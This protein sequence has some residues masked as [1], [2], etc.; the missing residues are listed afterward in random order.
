MNE[1]S[2]GDMSQLPDMKTVPLPDDGLILLPVRD[3]V[4]FPGTVFPVSTGRAK[5]IAAI[6]QVIR[7]SRPVGLLLQRNPAVND[8]KEG[9]LHL[10]GC[11]ANILRLMT[12]PDGAHHI[13][14][15]GV[16]RFRLIE[17]LQG[18]PFPVGRVQ[19]LPDVT[20]RSPQVEAQYLHLRNQAAELL[21]MLPQSPSGFEEAAQA[22][23]E[24]GTLA[25]LAAAYSD[26][27]IGEK[28]EI[29]ETIDIAVRLDKVSR[30]LARRLAVLRIT[31]EISERT[32]AAFDERHRQAILRE[33]LAAI[34]QELGE[35]DGN[36]EEVAQLGAAITRAGMPTEAE[37]MAR[38]ELG[39]FARLSE[40][41]GEGAVL[42]N[43]LDWMIE[44]PWQLP[45][46]RPVSLIQARNI[47]NADHYG[48]EKV[49][50]RIVEFMAVHK[51][52]PE[53]RAPILCF[54]GPP[55]VGKTSLG[56]SIARAL[57][58][59]FVR[60]SLGGV[61]DE[62]EIRGHRRTYIGALPGSI[63]Q[64]VRRAGSRN[65]VLMLDEIDKLGHGIQGDP[66][67]ALL[68]VLDPEQNS[69]F[70]DNYLGVD[71]DLSQIVFLTT[72]NMLEGIPRPLLDRMEVIN[73]PGYTEEEK[74]EI[75][76]RYLVLRQLRACGLQNERIRFTPAA[77]RLIVRSY[78]RE[79]GVRQLES[80]IGAVLRAAAVLHAEGKPA[81]CKIG[82]KQVETALGV[83]RF[84]NETALRTSLTGVATGLAWTPAGGDILF[85]EASRAPG[86]GRLILTGQLGEVMR[87]SA[88]TALSLLKAQAGQL[89]LK[90][91][92]FESVDI[93]VHVP[94]GAT[95]KDGPSAG[96]AIYTALASLFLDRTVR[97]D[98][99]MTGEI[100]LRGAVLPVGGIKE[101][102]LAASAAG[103]TRVMLP[104]RNRRE[105][106]D[107][108]ESTRKQL[109]FIWLDAADEALLK[110]LQ[111]EPGG[112]TPQ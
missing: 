92:S 16:E 78:T 76:K 3:L 39:R 95:P 104:S 60:I 66:S 111:P 88:Q 41:A 47:L 109:E 32:R 102:M 89:G 23:T 55:G 79:A 29:L 34:Q 61:H 74:L 52:S 91:K 69:A 46:S 44:L 68:E 63:L 100:S 54:A 12:S 40:A 70:R 38:K 50:A 49:K 4:P 2:G 87:E 31:R 84:E 62:A 97:S 48:L 83:P 18:P 56:Q 26:I 30:I 14:C 43:W 13:I 103:V 27:S 82:V 107:L 19:T 86:K 20:S 9:D 96:V 51:L 37:T 75:A 28:Q 98:T 72:A 1:A 33:Q 81:K 71:F 11:T 5:S 8:P 15:Q 73:L 106:E 45:S 25:D 17:L 105:L 6:Q 94:A 85:I 7:Q 80:Q 36:A 77:L 108:P 64:A 35:A 65:C 24:P 22:A 110:A 21:S 59:T 58:R 101:K 42:R 90:T 53:G 67:A 112:R 99:A 93:H 10:I 57:G